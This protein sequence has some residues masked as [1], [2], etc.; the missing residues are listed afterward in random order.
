MSR[1]EPVLTAASLSAVVSA[2]LLAFGIKLTDDLNDAIDT[3]LVVVAALV[4]LVTG[5]LARNRVT[6]LD[7]PRDANGTPL[8]P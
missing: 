2:V 4:P 3:L 7:D 6:P 1:P 5:W 8:T